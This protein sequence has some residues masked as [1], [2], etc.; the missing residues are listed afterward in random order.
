MD[1][2][3]D[4]AWAIL[5]LVLGCVLVVLEVFIP[6]GGIIAILAGIALITSILIASWEGETTGPATGF[7]FAAITVFAVPTLIGLAFKYW[8]KTRFGKAFLGEPPSEDEVL[9]HDPR[10]ALLGRVGV[11]RTKMLPS[12]AVEVDGQMIDAVSQ[13]QAIEPGTYVVVAEVRA[14]RV[15]VRPAGKDQR[16]SHENPNDV[17]SRPIEEL[18]IESLDEPLA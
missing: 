12:G 2:I 11:V 13:G 4:I 14:N 5:L 15:L 9:P 17:L 8:P 16:P 6:S 3:P 10:R 7:I 18:G 1:V